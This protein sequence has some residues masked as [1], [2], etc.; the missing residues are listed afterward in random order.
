M[1]DFA[2]QL[3]EHYPVVYLTNYNKDYWDVIKSKF[4]FGTPFSWGVVSYEIKARK[5]AK[6]CFQYILKKEH[7]EPE[8]AVFVDDTPGNLEEAH[9]LGIWT[10][11]FK[12]KDTLLSDLNRCGVQ[13]SS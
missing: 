12:N 6:E 5:P 7:C 4:D 13:V 8:E 1:L 10:I 2:R 11:Q 9:Q 3:K